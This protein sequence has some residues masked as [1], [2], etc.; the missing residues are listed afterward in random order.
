MGVGRAPTGS[1]PAEQ[2]QRQ[3]QLNDDASLHRERGE[4]SSCERSSVRA[5]V[6]HMGLL[7][8]TPTP[9]PM[10]FLR[11]VLIGRVNERAMLVM[12]V[13]YPAPDA[14]V[15]DLTRQ[16]LGGRRGVAMMAV[17]GRWRRNPLSPSGYAVGIRCRG[18]PLSA[19][20]TDCR[21]YPV[22]SR[23]ANSAESRGACAASSLDSAGE[24]TVSC[25]ED[26]AKKQVPPRHLN[27]RR[28]LIHKWVR[29][30]DHEREDERVRGECIRHRRQ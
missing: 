18:T 16:P 21:D 15:P 19:S 27:H 2:E 4:G 11:E 9:N 7:T 10:G 14:Q 3:R 29:P 1:S 13:G 6:H 28:A 25:A 8:L 5:A 22:S 30:A 26:R 24:P 23:A 17:T 12:P 20:L